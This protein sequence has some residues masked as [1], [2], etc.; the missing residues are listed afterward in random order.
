MLKPF[1]VRFWYS[2][3]FFLVF[4][5]CLY[6]GL[7]LSF[8]LTILPS[9]VGAT[10]YLKDSTRLVGLIGCLVGIGE[11]AGSGISAFVSRFKSLERG[12]IVAA[13]LISEYIAYIAVFSM[14]PA[15]STMKNTNEKGTDPFF[16]TLKITA[17]PVIIYGRLRWLLDPCQGFIPPNEMVLATSALIFGI[18]NAILNA[19][20]F[21]RVLNSKN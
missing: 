11:I 21:R 2:R 6:A 4:L 10:K 17:Q 14:L 5:I 3:E 15:K 8:I 13:G 20:F 19:Q 1:E 9:C 7:Q 12:P 18:S 16:S